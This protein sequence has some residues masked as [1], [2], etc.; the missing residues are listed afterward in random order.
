MTTFCA[1]NPSTMVADTGCSSYRLVSYGGFIPQ[2]LSSL[3][4]SLLVGIFQLAHFSWL[5]TLFSEFSDQR[6]ESWE[7]P[8]TWL[9]T[10]TTRLAPNIMQ[11]LVGNLPSSESTQQYYPLHTRLKL[12][13]T[14]LFK[15]I[16]GRL[17]YSY[18]VKFFLL[19]KRRDLGA[20]Q[21]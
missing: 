15:R 17:P 16:Y 5:S 7:F 2:K 19:Q 1:T 9:E 14:E 21:R 12:F 10:S 4:C 20:L 13:P 6:K 3:F 18:L 8:V 11:A